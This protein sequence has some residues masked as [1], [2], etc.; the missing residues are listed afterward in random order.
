MIHVAFCTVAPGRLT[1]RFEYRDTLVGA[2]ARF[3]LQHPRLADVIAGG[4]TPEHP[5]AFVE[6]VVSLSLLADRVICHA[7]HGRH[8]TAGPA[9]AAMGLRLSDRAG[10]CVLL[11]AVALISCGGM[12]ATDEIV[13][14]D[15]PHWLV[16]LMPYSDCELC[17]TMLAAAAPPRTRT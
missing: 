14:V 4:R 12:T 13:V 16:G 1:W 7:A 17:A 9:G 3:V 15:R 6:D 10:R 11:P 2:D 5:G 8:M